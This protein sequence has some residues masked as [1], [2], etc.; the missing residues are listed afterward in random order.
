VE[1]TRFK[2]VHCTLNRSF[3]SKS[4]D[5]KSILADKIVEHQKQVKQLISRHGAVV[6][7]KVSVSH[8][9]GGL[10][11]VKALLCET[12]ELNP[13]KGVTFRGFTVADICAQ[14]PSAPDVHQP[15]PEG[16]FWLMLTGEMPTRDQVRELSRQFA[17]HSTLPDHV[18]TMLNNFPT[19]ME[20]MA[21]FSA[22]IT[23][24]SVE[25]IFAQAH[26]Q[27]S[28]IKNCT[29]LIKYGYIFR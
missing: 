3:S 11:G 12:S 21:Q 28:M 5:L 9:Y 16:M 26:N 8:L 6:I 7:D 10:R 29:F 2:L 25:S 13:M 19:T 24:C 23:A 4:T 27:V 14:L 18:V 17:L 1:F 15:L 20:P 22:A